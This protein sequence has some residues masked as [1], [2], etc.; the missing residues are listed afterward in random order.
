LPIF[1]RKVVVVST[2]NPVYA[3]TWCA[4]VINM[5]QEQNEP[6]VQEQ[7][8]TSNPTDEQERAV[9]ALSMEGSMPAG[10]SPSP[11]DGQA[12]G[13]KGAD[14]TFLKSVKNAWGKVPQAWGQKRT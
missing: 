1:Y 2:F 9:D 11:N 13:S 6:L 8:T 5:T 12:K 10:D 3:H 7:L 4:D 14:K